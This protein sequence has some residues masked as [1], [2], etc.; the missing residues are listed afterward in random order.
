MKKLFAVGLPLI[1]LTVGLMPGIFSASGSH[2]ADGALTAADVGAPKPASA[3][4]KTLTVMPGG[5]MSPL[6]ITKVVVG[7]RVMVLG[8]PLSV[9]QYHSNP[10]LILNN[11]PF[12][13]GRG[14][15]NNMTIYVKNRTDKTVASATLLL[16]FPETGN[17]RTQPM[18][19]YHIQLG[20]MPDV[21]AFNGKTGK[22]LRIDPG[23]KPLNLQPGQEVVIQVGDYMD[24]IKAYVEKAMPL[25]YVTRV[26]VSVNECTFSDG[27]RYSA[28]AYS[29]PDASNHGKW[30]YLSSHY[31]PGDP[32]RYWPPN[33]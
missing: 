24:K 10:A 23:A 3:G 30:K 22:P 19:V 20:R 16:N 27:M 14:W 5:L 6:F 21:D 33:L 2:A 13:A 18:W 32:H 7:K 15:L 31:F 29:V 1:V 8:T 11:K 17:G 28:G 4:R 9:Q 12:E 26:G 25:F